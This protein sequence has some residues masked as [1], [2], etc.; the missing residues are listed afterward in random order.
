MAMPSYGLRELKKRRT[1][2]EIQAEALRLFAVQGYDA[3][4]CEQIAAE[5][6]VSP[7]TFFRY[8]P[9]KEDVVFTDDYDPMLINFLTMQPAEESPVHALRGGLA[10]AFAVIDGSDRK[11]IQER[12]RLVLETPALRARMYEQ[13]KQT[14]ELFAVHFAPR[15]HRPADDLRVR[16]VAGA[17]MST[18]V[19]AVERWVRQGGELPSLV[20]EALSAWEGEIS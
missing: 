15:M 20:D 2:A 5:A 11:V 7:A 16:V 9:T 17:V 18:L 8:F 4:T 13:L 1:R 6:Q 12:S 10:A 3:T 19:I 14:E